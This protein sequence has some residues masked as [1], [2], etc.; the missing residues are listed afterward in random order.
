MSNLVVIQNQVFMCSHSSVQRYQAE[1]RFGACNAVE[2][3][4]GDDEEDC[5]EGKAYC[6]YGSGYVVVFVDCGAVEGVFGSAVLERPV[7]SEEH[8]EGIL[9]SAF[10]E[11]EEVKFFIEEV[12]SA[13]TNEGHVAC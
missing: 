11:G 13:A 6:C 8:R 5:C 10:V 3:Y 12:F 4:D 7:G 2:A 9:L 1:L